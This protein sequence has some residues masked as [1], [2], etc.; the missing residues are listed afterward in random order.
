VV[1]SGIGLALLLLTGLLA[2]PLIYHLFQ[3]FAGELHFLVQV[4]LAFTLVL[5]VMALIT[6]VRPLQEPRRLPVRAG[7]DMRTDPMVKW[8]GLAVIVGVIIFF[9][10]FW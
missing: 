6:L 8:S 2:G 3:L 7:L 4:T 1:F 5:A 9:I 10:R